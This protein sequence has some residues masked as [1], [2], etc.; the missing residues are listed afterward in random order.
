MKRFFIPILLLFAISANA[1][2][3]TRLH[4]G[5]APWN[6]SDSLKILQ[7]Q[8]SLTPV[9]VN[10]F[11]A[12][13]SNPVIL[14]ADTS[15]TG[16][17]LVGTPLQFAVGVSQTWAY[18]IVII[19]SSS[20]SA[21]IEFGF[22]I[23]TGATI[24]S[25]GQGETTSATATTYDIIRAGA[26]AGTAVATVASGASYSGYTTSG[27][28]TTDGTHTGNIILQFLKVTSGTAIIKAGSYIIAWRVS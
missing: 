8:G 3:V 11:N 19:D 9:W 23:P 26:T 14:A 22:A 18:K 28:I 1:Q 5:T 21:G 20:S 12:G 15:T 6:S 24:N 10:A 25:L 7:S 2:R 17:A 16:Q 27:T 4:G 13:T